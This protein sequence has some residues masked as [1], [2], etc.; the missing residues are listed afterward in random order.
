[1]AAQDNEAFEAL[2]QYLINNFNAK[3]ASGG[4]EVIKKCHFCGDSRDPSSRHLY[5]GMRKGDGAIVYNCFKCNSSGYVDGKF[6]R[7]L[8]CYDPSIMI[9][10]EEHNRKCRGSNSTQF[11]G[12]G[13]GKSFRSRPRHFFLDPAPSEYTTKKLNYISRRFGHQISIGDL[14]RFKI[15]LNVK[16]CLLNNGITYFTRH[17]DMMDLLDKFFV[18][19]L[20]GD[21]RFIVLRRLVPEGK[22]PKNIDS[23]YVNYNIYGDDEGNKFYMIPTVVDPSRPVDIHIAEGAFDILSVYMHVAPLGTNGVFAAVCGKAYESLV[24]Y[25]IVNNGFMNFNLHLYL[26][27]DVRND[28]V[29]RLSRELSPFYNIGIYIHRNTFQGEKDFGVPMNRIINSSSKIY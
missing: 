29:E 17:P 18:G 7:D 10:C 11:N 5:I 22:L 12:S 27:N 25:L 13:S 4:K 15:V 6:L 3:P 23:R 14:N 19:F 9:L 20:S 8:G 2:K 21:N 28:E 16:E 26:D 24:R 1:M